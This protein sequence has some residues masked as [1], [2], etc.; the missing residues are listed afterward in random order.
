MW[1]AA[2]AVV[3]FAGTA[4]AQITTQPNVNY[5]AAANGKPAT[6]EPQGIISLPADGS[7]YRVYCDYGTPAGGFPSMAVSK[8]GPSQVVINKLG[9]HPTTLRLLE[10]CRQVLPITFCDANGNTTWTVS[11]PHALTKPAAGLYVRARIQVLTGL[12]W[13]DVPMA[14]SYA[15][16]PIPE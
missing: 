7:F 2:V 1:M 16:V 9:V 12:Q 15:P 4:D 8:G 10:A 14:V 5:Q 6:A 11:A 13:I 3:L